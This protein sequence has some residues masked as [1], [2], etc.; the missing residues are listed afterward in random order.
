M[1]R[2]AMGKS[3][4]LWGYWCYR[5]KEGVQSQN[6]GICLSRDAEAQATA[7]TTQPGSGSR[8]YTGTSFL[9]VGTSHSITVFTFPGSIWIL[10]LE[11]RYSRKDT[12]DW[13]K[14]PFLAFTNNCCYN[15]LFRMWQTWETRDFKSWEKIRMSS[16]YTKTYFAYHAR[17]NLQ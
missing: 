6:P 15:N 13:W 3:Q 14:S 16:R 17:H 9:L 2:L 10:H 8:V 7:E 1:N 11:I 4:E 12:D 5:M